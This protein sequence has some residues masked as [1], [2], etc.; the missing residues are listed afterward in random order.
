LAADLTGAPPPEALVER[1]QELS[2]G[3]EEI[4]DP[5]ARERAEEMIAVVLDLYGEGLRRIF[6][7]LEDGGEAA[8]ELRRALADDGVV[9]SLMLIHDLY[10]VSLTERVEEALE[11]VRPYMD[12]HGGGVELLGVTDGVAR[13]RLSGSCDGCPAS[14]ATLELAIKQALD[15]HA[16]DL[17]GLEVEGA[18]EA[19]G[20]MPGANGSGGT[21]LPVVQSAAA[22]SNGS[23]A[24]GDLEALPSWFPL[25]DLG[26]IEDGELRATAVA[27]RALLI[28]NV[29][30]SLLAYRDR[31]ADCGAPLADSGSTLV[32][33]VLCCAGCG[34]R[35]YLPRA[36]RS[37]DEDNLQLDPIP[38]IS[39]VGSVRVALAG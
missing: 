28:A 9:A 16:P 14:S 3:L 17:D 34:R 18:V 39:E 13:I 27:G 2:A 5:L 25:R 29:E 8:A 33:G 23:S 12:S 26:P 20:P 21:E 37:L 6:G 38:L 4:S 1:F 36:G 32:E 31:C 19:P 24:A 11:S 30:G 22:P 7:A 10:P 15:Q 35:Y